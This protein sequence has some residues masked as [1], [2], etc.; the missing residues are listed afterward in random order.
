MNALK[1]AVVGACPYPVPQG[2]Q[3][4][5]RN[6]AL[7]FEE[8]GHEA[9]LVV[10]GY[11]LGEDSSGLTIHRGAK[12]PG[13]R[14][15]AAGPSFAKPILD[16]ALV[17]TLRRVVRR[18]GIDIVDAHNYEGLL[19]A[20]A[21]RKR[22]ILYHAHN[23]M[24]DE[25]PYYFSNPDYAATL[26][27]WLD[28]TFPK[29]ADHIVAPHDALKEY[30]IAMGCSED[31]ISV[32]PPWIDVQDFVAAA[33]ERK[34]AAVLYAGNL[35]EYQNIQLLF[36]VMKR[37]EAEVP[38]TQLVVVT[39]SDHI[40]EEARVV[41]SQDFAAIRRELARDV[42]FACPRTSW[43]GYPIKLLNAMAAALPIVCCESSAH[44]ITHQYNGLIVPDNDVEAFAA[45]L[46]RL[47]KDPDLRRNLGSKARKTVEEKHT[48]SVV[49]QGLAELLASLDVRRRA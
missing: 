45:S 47:M 40:I 23:A 18:E 8:A 14:K 13:A 35:D 26:G 22:P 34:D 1:V 7:A 20:L 15:T 39:S 6:T 30:L 12:L 28:K 4:Y 27:A 16:A 5:L 2:S 42:I 17:H 24:A 33:P 9:H 46:L 32:I 21:A 36:P 44:P 41:H 38:G 3:V 43:S 31:R 25:L 49:A 29:R 48:K 37:V 19:V 11:G 10:Y